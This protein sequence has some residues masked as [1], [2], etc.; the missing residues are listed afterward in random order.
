MRTFHVV[1]WM[2]RQKAHVIMFDR[3]HLEAQRIPARN[4][5]KHQGKAGDTFAFYAEVAKV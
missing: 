3:D 5:H 4:H 2:D 1:V